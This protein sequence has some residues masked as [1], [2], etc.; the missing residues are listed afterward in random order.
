MRPPDILM[1]EWSDPSR[2][3]RLRLESLT[4]HQ[5]L[6][7]WEIPNSYQFQIQ[8]QLQT[9]AIKNAT[10]K[11]Y[12]AGNVYSEITNKRYCDELTRL[13]TGPV[14]GRLRAGIGSKSGGRASK[15]EQGQ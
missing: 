1:S 6:E 13:D 15:I 14:R 12:R 4:S 5:S 11:S 7:K 8:D 3:G 9:S 10:T 2:I